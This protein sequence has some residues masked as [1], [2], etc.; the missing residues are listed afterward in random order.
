MSL[1]KRKNS[2]VWYIQYTDRHGNRLQVS[3]RTT[4]RQAAQELHDK[5]K[6]ESWRQAN[7]KEKPKY[8]WRDAALKW[9]DESKH[10][11]SLQDDRN[12]LR[13]LEEHLGGLMLEQIDREVVESIKQAKAE[14]TKPAT[15]NRMLALVR[16]ILNKCEKEWEWIEK[17]PHVK[18]LALQN[19]RIR[20]LTKSESERLLLELP[21]HL[22]EMARFSLA[23]GLRE[24]NVTNLRWSQVDLSRACAWIY[25]DEAKGKRAIAVPL[26]EDA[27]GVIRRQ[28]G[29]HPEYVFQY[30]GIPVKKAGTAA[31][32]KA[33]E[34]CGID[35]FRWHDLRH[36]FA[37]W[38]VQAGTPLHVLQELGGWSCYSMVQRYAHLSPGHLA[39]HAGNIDS[40]RKLRV[41]R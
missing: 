35:G 37:S 3:A 1:Y 17:A 5:L 31:W 9:L 7:L 41:V 8:S 27:L 11:R 16:A 39:E 34:R 40:E 6:A 13:W 24:A 15:V 36:T 22:A 23:T 38:H 33:L 4:D 18:M 28:Q 29:K 32:K 20:W 26:N 25:H 10:K 30:K 19:K 14:T 21:P 2:P 12:H